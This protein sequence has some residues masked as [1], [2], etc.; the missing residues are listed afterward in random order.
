MNFLIKIS[1]LLYLLLMTGCGPAKKETDIEI[2]PKSDT[3]VSLENDSTK[4]TVSIMGGSLVGF[5]NK[6]SM[7]NPFNWKEAD[8]LHTDIAKN[9]SLLQGQFL[10]IGRW[11]L[12]TPGESKLGMP[13]NGEPANNWWKL[14]SVKYGKELK[15]NCEAPLDGFLVSRSIT[16]SQS[17]PLFKVIETIT[18]EFS[19]GRVCTVIQNLIFNTPFYDPSLIL[20]CNASFGFT[21]DWG[22]PDPSVH[23]YK[24]PRAYIDTLKISTMDISKFSTKF[25][26][27]SSLIF[28]DTI[29]WITAYNPKLKLL[30]GYVW[31]TNDY[32]WLH[33]INEINFGKPDLHGISFGTIGL[34]DKYSFENRITTTFHKVKNFDFI[35][36]KSSLIKQWYCFMID[37]H[38]DFEQTLS[39]GFQND[40]V[41]VKVSTSKGIKEVKLNL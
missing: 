16:L 30:L 34:S 13:S 11:N 5:Q 8:N 17:D 21:Q 40:R 33:I 19:I 22:L 20:N 27:T 10:S 25:K 36:A 37:I 24:W 1:I 31:K 32:P 38:D 26:Y 18:N 7:I 23:E 12:P 9:G 39:I 35:D 28:S 29:G 3:L 41:S 14:E 15:M 4:L 2:N 6:I